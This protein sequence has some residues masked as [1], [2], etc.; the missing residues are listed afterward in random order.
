MLLMKHPRRPPAD[1]RTLERLVRAALRGEDDNCAAHYVL[2]GL[3]AEVFGFVVA[4]LDDQ[5][6]ARLVY[7]R[8]ARRVARDVSELHRSRSLRVWIYGVVRE[9]LAQR[10]ARLGSTAQW[11]A[12]LSSDIAI[13]SLSQ[14]E[15]IESLRRQLN[16][17]DRELLILRVDRRF[18]W[19][20]VGRIT[21]GEGASLADVA[22][23]TKQLQW[24]L[25]GIVRRLELAM[26]R[27]GSAPPRWTG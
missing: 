17:E 25:A 21:V 9:E 2:T 18:E 24:R 1:D 4:V 7:E 11:A 8:I 10:R 20:D 3:G 16:E 23:R 6:A 15:R 13:S 22:L 12:G 26:R 19:D 5:E 14:A 27:R